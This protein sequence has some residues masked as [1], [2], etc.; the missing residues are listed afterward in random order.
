MRFDDVAG[1]AP[2]QTRIPLV[3]PPGQQIR[4]D[5]KFG[6]GLR[7]ATS[8]PGVRIYA[9]EGSGLWQIGMDGQGARSIPGTNGGLYPETTR[10]GQSIVFVSQQ[11]GF[12]RLSRI[13][14][15]GGAA[16]AMLDY[17]STRPSVSPDGTQVAFYVRKDNTSRVEL[18]IMPIDGK[19]PTRRFDVAPSGGYLAV[20]WT[21][22]GK[23]LLHNSA[24]GDR[25]NIWLQPLD[26]SKP[27]M[28]TRFS[29]QNV[30]AFDRSTD[31]KQVLIS[32]GTITRDAFLL[33]GF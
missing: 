28:I 12:E 18:G 19:A 7:V 16:V 30:M 25:A 26:G 2:M 6:L 23:A 15:A 5:A 29:D 1:G 17:F 22:D 31:G 32:R 21:A 9:R 4:T 33:K 14:I 8:S 11:A 10:D 24:V 13:P 3:A 27:R 20:R